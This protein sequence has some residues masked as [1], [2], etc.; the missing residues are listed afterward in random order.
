MAYS[1]ITFTLLD[2]ISQVGFSLDVVLD[3]I[4]TNEPFVESRFDHLSVGILFLDNLVDSKVILTISAV[5][6]KKPGS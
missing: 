4:K 3:L 1:G 5:N 2:V 6:F